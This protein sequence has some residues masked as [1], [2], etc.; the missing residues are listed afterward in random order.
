MNE[1]DQSTR[2]NVTRQMMRIL[3]Y[4]DGH[5][6]VV[7]IAEEFNMSIE[8]FEL[9]VETLTESDLLEPLDFTPKIDNSVSDL[10]GG[11]Q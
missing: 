5:H 9:A 3:N 4:S 7:D 8:E 1:P 2:G 11:N 10:D 6:S